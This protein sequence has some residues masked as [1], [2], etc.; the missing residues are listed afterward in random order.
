MELLD[1]YFDTALDSKDGIKKLRE[2][3]LTLAMKGKLVPQDPTDQPASELLKDIQEEK[4][5]LI[6]DGKIKKQKDLPPIKPEEIPYHLPKGWE[7]VR[8]GNIG[9]WQSGT[10][11]NRSEHTYYSGHIP[12]V[13]SGEV[14][15]GIIHTTEEHVSELAMTK[16]SLPL[17]QKGAILV[18]MYGANIGDIGVLAINA[19]TNQ[20]V[21][22][23]TLFLKDL[24]KYLVNALI[25]N[26]SY[27]LYI[28]AGAAQPNIS[29]EKII[30]TLIPIPPLAEQKRIVEKI[31]S[32]MAKCDELE[33]LKKETEQKKLDV[34][35]SAVHALLNSGNVKESWQFIKSNFSELYTVKENV[36]EL[37]KAIL[38]LAMMGKLVP[39][40]PADQPAS[41]LLKEIQAEKSKLIKEGKIKKQKDLLLIKPEEIPYQ[42][43]TSWEWVRLEELSTLITDGTHHTPSYVGNGVHFLSVKDVSSGKICF[44]E[45]KYITTQE[46][47]E[48][49]KRC[50]PENGDILFTKVG[51]TGIAVPIETDI[52]FSIFVSLALI[53]LTYAHIS[54]SFLTSLLNSPLVKKYSKEGTEGVGNKNL[55]LRKIKSFVIPLPPLAEQKRIVEKI[56]SL[57][58]ICDELEKQI[59]ESENK[60]SALLNSIMAQV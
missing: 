8:L 35:K 45:T 36:A 48:L 49:C 22:A 3:I 59:T 53:K 24:N 40:D 4:A 33:K 9:I 26:K 25:N 54:T 37:R 28:S 51:T 15:Q 23:C 50:M 57:L 11:P 27:F 16:C 29:R 21:C 58:A 56:D 44:E 5:K 39:Q 2:M 13:K 31:D 14:K 1:K 47:E 55:V 19:T 7:W 38:Q 32:L 46:H 17:I 41:E 34:H 30:N 42:I 43:P 60:K 10:T 12:W 6:K 20:A 52:K 18:A